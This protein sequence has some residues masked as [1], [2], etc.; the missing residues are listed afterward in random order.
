MNDTGNLYQDDPH[1]QAWIDAISKDCHCCPNC[2]DIPF[3][4]VQ[5][6]GLC[7]SACNCDD[8]DMW[9]EQEIEEDF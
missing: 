2:S 1:Y 5:A 6:G 3:A 7:D 9:D 8:H 4:G